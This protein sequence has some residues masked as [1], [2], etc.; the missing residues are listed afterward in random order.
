VFEVNGGPM[1]LTR[2]EKMEIFKKY[3]VHET[4][5]GSP[6]AQVAH[7]T[8]RIIRLTEHFKEHKK[9][10]SGRRGLIKLVSMRRRHLNYLKNTNFE[11]YRTIIEKL[12]LR[13]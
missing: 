3:G 12:G 9:D 6:E 1:A 8:E 13:K 7:L 5:T 4:D 11:R 10:F 2:D